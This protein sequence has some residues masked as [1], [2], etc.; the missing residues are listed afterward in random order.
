MDPTK[1]QIR[2]GLGEAIRRLFDVETRFRHGVAPPELIVERGML[3][4]ALNRVEI[5]LGFD[6]DGDGQPDTVEIFRKA[7]ET[8]CCRLADLTSSDRFEESS[9]LSE[10]VLPVKPKN[11][12]F[13][14]KIFAPPS[15]KK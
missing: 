8:S 5:Q 13:F 7:S 2:M 15:E 9:R 11:P 14:G 1:K 10:P 6:C 4:D 3:L 12:G